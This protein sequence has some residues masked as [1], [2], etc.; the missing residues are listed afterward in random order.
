MITALFGI[1]NP[2]TGEFTYSIAG[3]PRPLVVD[4]AGVVTVLDGGGTPLGEAFDEVFLDQSSVMLPRGAAVTF[5]TDGLIE[6]ARDVLHA[7]QRLCALLARRTFL[8]EENPAQAVIN[9]V[10]EG[11]Q[12]DD[13]AVLV[14]RL[15]EAAQAL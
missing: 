8:E 15:S 5:F 7:E 10:L 4:A 11:S 13:I 3:H 14:M 6:Y 1:Y 9:G 12:S 2:A